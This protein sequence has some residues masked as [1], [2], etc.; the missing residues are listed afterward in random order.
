MDKLRY[1]GRRTTSAGA[2]PLA[3]LASCLHV[4]PFLACLLTH[5]V[6]VV[7]IV[8]SGHGGVDGGVAAMHLTVRK[9]GTIGSELCHLLELQT[10]PASPHHPP[11]TN[12]IL[13]STFVSCGDAGKVVLS[14]LI[15]VSWI[16]FAS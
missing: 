8:D 15:F 16:R 6:V 11:P 7:V 10:L 4:L 3:F 13:S 5:L 2:M 1:V 14:S 12:L 9:A